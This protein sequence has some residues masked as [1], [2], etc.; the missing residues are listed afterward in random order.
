M[1]CLLCVVVGIALIAATIL[2]IFHIIVARALNLQF[3][4]FDLQDCVVSLF[5][6]GVH[7]QL[8]FNLLVTIH[9]ERFW[10]E[11]SCLIPVSRGVLRSRMQNDLL[12]SPCEV[13]VEPDRV[14]V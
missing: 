6:I 5:V 10:D 14:A 3:S 8:S 12:V 4:D 11:Q 13:C 7:R 9:S 1:F 2:G